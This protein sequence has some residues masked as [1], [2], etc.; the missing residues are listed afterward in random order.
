VVLLLILN[1][2]V[3]V[4]IILVSCSGFDYLS[5]ATDVDKVVVD[6]TSSFH[7]FRFV[8]RTLL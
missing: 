8:P 5:T 1:S 7:Q 6:D 3:V 4:D 2:V